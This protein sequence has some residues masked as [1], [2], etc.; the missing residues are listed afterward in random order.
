MSEG[1]GIDDLINLIDGAMSF[2]D[3]NED[4]IK[5]LTGVNELNIEDGEPLTDLHKTE[6]KVLITLEVNEDIDSISIKRD[7]G[8]ALFKINEKEFR[9][10]MP[11]DARLEDT[12]ANLN[13]GV[14]E[15]QIP[16]GD[17]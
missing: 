9:A 12:V 10:K 16:R 17:D 8:H 6:D 14:L 7:N 15:A 11:D 2:I 13:N 5:R 4:K 1:S 3:N